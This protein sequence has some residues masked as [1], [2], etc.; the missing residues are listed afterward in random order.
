MFKKFFTQTQSNRG[1]RA[2]VV[3]GILLSLAVQ[4]ALQV[5]AE[6]I[7]QPEG[8]WVATEG[9]WVAEDAPATWVAPSVEG[10]QVAEEAPITPNG[11]LR[12]SG[13]I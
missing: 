6:E 1:V 12:G 5:R 4:S 3:A 7:A 8:T 9:T 11:A 2:L 13:G 10:T